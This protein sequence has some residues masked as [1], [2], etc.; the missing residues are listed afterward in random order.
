MIN[1][2]KIE[3]I[4]WYGSPVAK[5]FTALVCLVKQIWKMKN[6]VFKNDIL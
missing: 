2:W 5:M 6:P 4:Y 1:A 3:P